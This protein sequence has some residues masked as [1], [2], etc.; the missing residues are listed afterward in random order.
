MRLLL[1]RTKAQKPMGQTSVGW[2]IC[3]LVALETLQSPSVCSTSGLLDDE[4]HANICLSQG[5]TSIP[6]AVHSAHKLAVDWSIQACC[7]HME[8][9]CTAATSAEAAGRHRHHRK[10]GSR[11]ATQST[12][13]A[14]VPAMHRKIWAPHKRYM[15]RAGLLVCCGKNVSVQ[16]LRLYQNK[17]DCLR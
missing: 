13:A 1:H 17:A 2:Q 12:A 10:V 14:G 16:C 4:A 7:T 6:H 3:Q 8:R 11:Q 9:C 5:S 15:T